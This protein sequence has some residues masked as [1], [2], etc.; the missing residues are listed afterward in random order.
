[1]D[2]ERALECID[3]ECDRLCSTDN[4][5]LLRGTSAKELE[6]LS[7]DRLASDLQTT[8]PTLWS[9][10]CTIATPTGKYI[11][12]SSGSHHPVECAVMAVAILLK[13]RCIQMSAIAYL[14]GLTLWQGNASTKVCVHA[15]FMPSK[16]C[17][18]LI[19]E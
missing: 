19:H 15:C 7:F 16:L 4:P 9:V 14:I 10:L 13:E 17:M 8:A 1:M 6:N 2:I 5:S 12:K 3:L 11:R 18:V